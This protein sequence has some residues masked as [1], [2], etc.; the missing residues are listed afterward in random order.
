MEFLNSF[1]IWDIIWFCSLVI[2]LIG[3]LFVK[4]IYKHFNSLKIE[5]HANNSNFGNINV[6]SWNNVVNQTIVNGF[7]ISNE[8]KI[9]LDDNWKENGK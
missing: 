9:N 1:N 4:P 5:S 2:W 6:N 8:S 7:Y 3:L